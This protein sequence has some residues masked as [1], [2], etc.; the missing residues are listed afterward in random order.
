MATK[1]T[2]LLLPQAL[3]EHTE[4]AA[5]LP[6]QKSGANTPTAEYGKSEGNATLMGD[7]TAQA[8]DAPYKDEEQGEGGYRQPQATEA[9]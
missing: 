3:I 4:N 8:S 1:G 2:A 7:P 5:F 6:P 9:E